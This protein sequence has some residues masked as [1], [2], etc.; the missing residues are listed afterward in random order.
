MTEQIIEV[1]LSQGIWTALSFILLFYII[2]AQEKRDEKQDER[3][4]KYQNLL[5]NLSDKLEIV[6]EIQDDITE[7]KSCIH[8]K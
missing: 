2:R 3:E 8:E 7:I 4:K 5:N 1:A 6:Q